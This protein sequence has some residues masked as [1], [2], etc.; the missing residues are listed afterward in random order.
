MYGIFN[1]GS[2]DWTQVPDWS[3]SLSSLY[4]DFNKKSLKKTL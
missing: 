3:I 2:G 1:V 4:I